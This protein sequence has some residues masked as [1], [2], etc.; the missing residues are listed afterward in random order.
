MTRREF[1]QVGA[2]L[3]ERSN[4]YL[5]DCQDADIW[6]HMAVGAIANYAALARSGVLEPSIAVAAMLALSETE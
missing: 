6:A 3:A 5:E 4:T 1:R 2:P